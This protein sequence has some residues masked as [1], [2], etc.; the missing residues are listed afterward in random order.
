MGKGFAPRRRMFAGSGDLRRLMSDNWRYLT[1]FMNAYVVKYD[2]DA[3]ENLSL[4]LSHGT[5]GWKDYTPVLANMNKG[6]GTVI[7]RYQD[8]SGTIHGEFFFQLG[9]SSTVGSSARFSLPKPVAAQYNG[10][11]GGVFDSA[12]VNAKY[13]FPGT[14]VW[15]GSG[16]IPDGLD[17]ISLEAFNAAGSLVKHSTVTATVPSTWAADDWM[18]VAFR[19]ERA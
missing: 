3:N 16:Y 1:S 18:G 2:V 10:P 17:Y 19:Y 11:A 15:S 12:L 5:S 7:A 9:S 13:A 4:D 6:N 14:G 8:V